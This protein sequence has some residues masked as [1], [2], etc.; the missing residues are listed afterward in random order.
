MTNVIVVSLYYS[1]FFIYILEMF[2][3]YTVNPKSIHIIIHY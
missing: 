3:F 2:F 1:T